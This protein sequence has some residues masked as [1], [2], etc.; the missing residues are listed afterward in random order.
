MT[1]SLKNIKCFVLDMDGTIYLGG[2]L[3]DFTQGFL[4]RAAQTGRRV[5][6]FTNNSSKNRH[7][8]V[9]KLSKM[10]IEI[11]EGAMMVSNDVIIDYLQKSHPGKSVFLLGTEYLKS[12]FSDGGI[13]LGAAGEDADIVVLGFDTTLE[14][15][16]LAAACDLIRRGAL[17]FAVN[18]DLNCPV[19]QKLWQSGFIPDCGAM[20]TAITAATG[21]QPQYFG[22]PTP[23]ALQYILKSTGFKESELAIVGDRLYTDIALAKDSGVTSILVLSG[24]SREEDIALSPHK[25]DFVVRDIG[26]LAEML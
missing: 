22:K 25:P 26:E 20:A 11:D 21:V 12:D 14:Y 10:G 1:K 6:F 4:N 3:F 13:K 7:A 24:E 2:K 18:P 17:F 5:C 19:E 16:R 8:Y 23:A 15:E 9:E